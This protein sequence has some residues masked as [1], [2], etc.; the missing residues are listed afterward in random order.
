MSLRMIIALIETMRPKQWIKNLLVYAGVIFS[1]RFFEPGAL[2]RATA[3]FILFSLISGSVYI[4]NDL[5]DYRRDLAHPQKKMRPIPSG[6]LPRSAALVYLIVIALASFSASFRLS[7]EF[8]IVALI[9]FI[10]NIAYSIRL[11]HVVIIDVMII[12]LGFVLRAL[13]GSVVIHVEFSHWLL[14][15]TLLLALF[16]AIC[17][18]RAE[19]NLIKENAGNHRAVLD[20]Y[21]PALVDQMTSVVTASALVAYALYTISPEVTTK[22]QTD[23]LIYTFPFVL[24]AIFRYLYLVMARDEGGS[25]E[26]IFLQDKAMII[27]LIGWIVTVMGILYFKP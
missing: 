3:A 7:I 13:A 16:L 21:T 11:K 19:M 18:R 2:L 27:D 1:L 17:K 12:A 9:Y 20:H 6:R 14:I 5:L 15:C 22:L 24:F 8:G 25:P 23:N 10:M 26:K 4:M